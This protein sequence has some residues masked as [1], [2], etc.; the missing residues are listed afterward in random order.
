MKTLSEA[1]S[2]L[3]KYNFINSFGWSHGTVVEC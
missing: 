3:D 2:G 1:L